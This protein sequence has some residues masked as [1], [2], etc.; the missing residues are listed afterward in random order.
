[1]SY[2]DNPLDKRHFHGALAN[3]SPFACRPV[4]CLGCNDLIQTSC[5]IWPADSRICHACWLRGV[6]DPGKTEPHPDAPL[7]RARHL[8]L[9]ET[10]P[11]SGGLI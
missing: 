11:T 1:M 10:V 5:L 2:R 3:R 8:R 6:R 4:V 7:R 9:V